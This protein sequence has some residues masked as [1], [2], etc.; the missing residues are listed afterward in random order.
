MSRSLTRG[1]AFLLG[2]ILLVGLFLAILAIFLV[3]SRHWPGRNDLNV[4]VGFMEIR[5]VE[6]GTRVRI[7]GLDSGEVTSIQPPATPGQPILLRLRIQGAQRHLVLAGSM[8][9]IV[10]EGMLG[11]KV[12][13]IQA[14]RK[15]ARPDSAFAPA[16]EGDLL[17]SAPSQDLQDL[18][19]RVSGTLQGIEAGNGTIG[20]LLKDPQAYEALVT[21]LKSSSEAVAKGNSTITNLQRDAENLKKLPII[22]SYLEDPVKVLVRPDF[23]SDRRVLEEKELFES[24]RASLTPEGKKALDEVAAWLNQNKPRGSEVVVV[25]YAD[26]KNPA[27]DTL[28]ALN[29]TRKQAEAVAAYLRDTHGVHRTGWFSSRTLTT[30]GQ[31]VHPPPLPE[32]EPLP[33]AR[34]EVILFVPQS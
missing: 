16:E 32:K 5:G 19:A 33:P 11:A 22:G 34:T 4:L 28:A 17:A 29:I 26:P 30:L 10:S 8:V 9:S 13:E 6:V 15:E 20:R 24:N 21:L 2:A 14:P 18:L 23:A 31:G 3:G 12:L 7:Q 1:Q 25:T 27:G